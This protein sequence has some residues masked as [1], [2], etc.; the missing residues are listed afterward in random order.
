MSESR[1]F[2]SYLTWLALESAIMALS[3]WGMACLI[4][5]AGDPT[6]GRYIAPTTILL[7]VA[8]AIVIQLWVKLNDLSALS[9]LA[10]AE[11]TKLWKIVRAK[12]RALVWLVVF[13]VV[14]IF[15]V[16]T[17]SILS[18]A[19]HV[20]ARPVLLG[21]GAGCGACLTLIAGVLID[22][23]E[24]AQFRWTVEISDQ[25]RRRR[26][27]DLKR[28]SA[29]EPGFEDDEHIQGYKRISNGS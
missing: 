25:E 12:V 26:D 11:R 14:F 4:D 8:V 16:L 19:E 27:A 6:V 17:A 5:V 22:L 18:A 29:A 15:L 23:N 20:A 1:W 24:V 13:F 10:T 2:D 28:L 9:S 7:S 3:T 21:I